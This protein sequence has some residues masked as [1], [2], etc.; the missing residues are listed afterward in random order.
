MAKPTARH[1]LDL[2]HNLAV[3]QAPRWT[4]TYEL[5]G[6]RGPRR[7]ATERTRVAGAGQDRVYVAEIDDAW[8]IVL[9]DG[10]GGSGDGA[11]A[12][13]R[14]CDLVQ[15]DQATLFS[16]PAQLGAW[17]TGVDAETLGGQTTAIVLVVRD[18]IVTGVSV[19]D[20]EAWVVGATV[21]ALT[22]Q[23]HRKPLLGSGT[24]LPVPFDGELHPEQTLVLG[25]DGL[26]KYVA[27][28]HLISLVTAG[29]SDATLAAQLLAAARLP[30]GR[31]QDDCSVIVMRAALAAPS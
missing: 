5:E 21:V 19:G 28:A 9:A 18:G 14:L 20:S 17:L 26:F 29:S 23:Q 10:A 2:R 25:S 6:A 22:Q 27:A 3:S 31:L 7:E 8:L 16:A 11:L 13:Q 4:V 1:T 30:T 12:A 15:R 24:A